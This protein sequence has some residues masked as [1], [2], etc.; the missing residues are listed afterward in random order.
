MRLYDL[1]EQYKELLE[2]AETGDPIPGE[3]LTSLE[4]RIEHKAENVAAVIKTLEHEEAAL[5]AEADRLASRA[6]GV[7][8]NRESLKAYLERTLTEAKLAKI[9]GRLF[10]V[11]LAKKAP[12]VEIVDE[13]AI[14]LTYWKKPD[15]VL[16][17][18]G[19]LEALKNGEE[20]PGAA[21]NTSGQS[22]RIR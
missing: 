11:T 15:P 12:G 20:I 14:P 21:L 5:K 16:D 17:R 7:K 22:L 1:T 10:T 13:K 4:D 8:K 2:M 6:H 9:K 18:A 3:W 19:L